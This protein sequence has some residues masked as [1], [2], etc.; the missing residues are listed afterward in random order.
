M[1][2]ILMIVWGLRVGFCT[3]DKILVNLYTSTG[4]PTTSGLYSWPRD[5]DILGVVSLMLRAMWLR[6]AFHSDQVIH[7]YR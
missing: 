5:S 1:E 4:Q 3:K 7:I 2:N 6:C